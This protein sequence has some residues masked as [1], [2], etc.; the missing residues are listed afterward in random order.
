MLS[1]LRI[2]HSKPCD[3]PEW[4]ALSWRQWQENSKK[5]DTIRP[6]IMLVIC[7]GAVA[8][9]DELLHGEIGPIVNAIQCRLFQEEFKH[10]SSFP[11]QT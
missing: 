4:D 9:E 11:V 1:G 10:T 8:Q 3:L 7:T 5:P 2:G 6:H